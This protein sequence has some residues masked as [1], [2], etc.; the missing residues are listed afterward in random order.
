MPKIRWTDLE[1]IGFQLCEL[2]P[3]DDPLKTRFTD[4]HAW[5][6]A[7]PEFV[8]DAKASNEAKLEA[9]QM[10]WL[11]EY[12]ARLKEQGKEYTTI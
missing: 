2:H 6:L 10:A 5:I 8:D 11:D 7:L 4:M 1:E 9:I 12:K 3:N